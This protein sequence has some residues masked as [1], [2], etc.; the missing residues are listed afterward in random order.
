M[1]RMSDANEK[2][3]LVESEAALTPAEPEL[4]CASRLASRGGRSDHDCGLSSSHGRSIEELRPRAQAFADS[5]TRA[6]LRQLNLEANVAALRPAVET[7]VRKISLAWYFHNLPE[8][9]G[10]A[11][12]LALDKKGIPVLKR[13]ARLAGS[14]LWADCWKHPATNEAVRQYI[15]AARRKV[16]GK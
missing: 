9:T 1:K 6:A 11:L 7:D 15:S 3:P 8:L 4:Q 16:L 13:W 2:S 12:C 14:R 10:L 5:Q